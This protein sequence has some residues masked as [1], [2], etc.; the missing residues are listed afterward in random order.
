VTYSGVSYPN[1]TAAPTDVRR[2][3]AAP[4]Y[5]LVNTGLTYTWSAGQSRTKQ[6]IR[7]SAKN[8]LDREYEDQKGNYGVVGVFVA[9]TLAH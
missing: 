5:C 4:G 7:L 9:Y 6:S 8:L 2:Y 1:S 3:I